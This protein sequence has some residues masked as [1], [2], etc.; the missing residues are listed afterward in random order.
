VPYPLEAVVRDT[1]YAYMNSTAA[2]AVAFAVYLRVKKL[3][4]FGMDFTYAHSHHSEKGRACVE[5]WLGLAAARDIQL[6]VP[7]RSSLM[8][9]CEPRRDRLYGYDTV[10]V[11]IDRDAA[12][13]HTVRFTERAGP[14]PTAEEIEQ[15]YDHT[16]HPNPLIKD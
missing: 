14:L 5:F 8:D 13:L 15:R 12:G 7:Q 1:G 6:S 2:Y 9:G 10:D 11:V 3:T 4:L 16:V